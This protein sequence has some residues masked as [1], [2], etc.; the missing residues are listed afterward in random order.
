KVLH[1]KG[2]AGGLWTGGKPRTMGLNEAKERTMR[3]SSRIAFWLA[4]CL[5]VMSVTAGAQNKIASLERELFNATNRERLAHGV[6][7][8]RWND[9]LAVAARKH[10]GGMAAKDT[11]SHQ[12]AGEPSLPSRV[13]QTGA[14]L[15]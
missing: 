12:F 3:I 15:V 7:T 2:V 4:I 11:L 6:P 1:R 13:K 14:R 8:L 10:A 5:A 9:S